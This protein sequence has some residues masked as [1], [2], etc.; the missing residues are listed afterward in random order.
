MSSALIGHTGFVGGNL[1]RQMKFDEF[2][3]SKNINDIRGRTLDLVV[4]AGVPGRKWYANERPIEDLASILR[5]LGAVGEVE[6]TRFVLISTVDVYAVPREV[7]ED[8][9]P[10]TDGLRPYGRNRRLLEN[11]VAR[12]FG[13][14]ATILRLPA[15]FGPGLRKNALFDLMNGRDVSGVPAN[16]AYQWYPLGGLGGSMTRA[17][18]E[19][20]TVAN[21]VSEPVEMSAIQRRFFPAA[22][23]GPPSDDAPS[24]SVE[25]RYGRMSASFVLDEMAEFLRRTEDVR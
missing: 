8:V 3:N 11:I 2:Y 24:Y 19:G 12:T 10:T 5:L 17:I 16:A 22:R 23:L 25:S 7:D 14:R 21:L 15:L 13:D 9:R 4:C 6:T 18:D 1:A 20:R